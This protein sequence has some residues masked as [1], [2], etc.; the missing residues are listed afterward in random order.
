MGHTLGRQMCVLTAVG[1][2]G[3]ISTRPTTLN[4]GLLCAGLE[5]RR[6]GGTTEVSKGNPSQRGLAST[7]PS[8]R[9]RC[10]VRLFE[11]T[12]VRGKAQGPQGDLGSPSESQGLRGLS[13]PL[14]EISALWAGSVP[15]G[16][17]PVG[18][19]GSVSQG[20]GRGL[21]G[22]GGPPLGG[23]GSVPPKSFGAVGRVGVSVSG[24][25]RLPPPGLRVTEGGG[26]PQLGPAP[27]YSP[28]RPPP[29]TPALTAGRA[30]AG[31][32]WR[33]RPGRPGR[34]CSGRGCPRRGSPRTG[35]GTRPAA[36]PAAP[37]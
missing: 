2:R 25:R 26:G 7:P 10:S 36:R 28:A 33:R 20:A 5:T 13:V 6:P 8:P 9:G 15:L 23:G 30:G 21:V 19:T 35:G 29:P 18:G 27:P 17:G 34:S 16:H 11:S 3:C 14:A 32:G 12:V 22:K 37:P 31:A 1:G 4:G 24:G